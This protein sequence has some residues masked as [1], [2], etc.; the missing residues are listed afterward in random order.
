MAR[1]P[2]WWFET[3]KD[4]SVTGWNRSLPDRGRDDF[5]VVRD[6]TSRYGKDQTGRMAVLKR[7]EDIDVST[8]GRTA[9][10][11]I[12]LLASDMVHRD[13]PGNYAN[14]FCSWLT[15]WQN[16]TE[17][18]GVETI[19]LDEVEAARQPAARREPVMPTPA[20]DRANRP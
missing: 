20:A 4:G 19:G 17:A 5:H 16:R 6:Q 8:S 9:R 2:V 7:H 3:H 13:A 11:Q 10:N 18:N 1:V 15:S 14:L 12:I